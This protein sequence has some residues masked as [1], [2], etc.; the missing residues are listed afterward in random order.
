MHRVNFI[1]V[2][3]LKWTCVRDIRRFKR[4][5]RSLSW[6]TKSLIQPFQRAGIS[7]NE[8]SSCPSLFR[9]FFKFSFTM[10]IFFIIVTTK[11][12]IH[13]DS[14][15][16]INDSKTLHNIL[17]DLFQFRKIGPFVCL[18]FLCVFYCR[19]IMRKFS[20]LSCTFFCVC[21][22]FCLFCTFVQLILCIAIEK[23]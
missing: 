6:T 18:N 7:A 20:Q 23:L 12:L 3:R 4:V 5:F 17:R 22:L 15:C 19:W 1:Y 8:S 9:F 21:V 11:H 16:R 2:C 13:T 14:V 10:W